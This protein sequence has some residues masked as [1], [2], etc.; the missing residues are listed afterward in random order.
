MSNKLK[1]HQR[2]ANLY[3]CTLKDIFY[4]RIYIQIL[5]AQ[6][7]FISLLYSGSWS[8]SGHLGRKILLYQI[9]VFSCGCCYNEQRTKKHEIVKCEIRLSCSLLINALVNTNFFQIKLCWL[10]E[11]KFSSTQQRISK[12]AQY[13]YCFPTKPESQ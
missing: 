1:Q 9:L 8:F 10:V 3:L 6:T 11:L 5:C 4:K 7:K 13:R 2:G 12:L